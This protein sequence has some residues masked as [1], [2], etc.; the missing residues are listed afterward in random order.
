M[1]T[2][3]SRRKRRLQL[4]AVALGDPRKWPKD[5]GECLVEAFAPDGERA[6]RA[7]LTFENSVRQTTDHVSLTARYASMFVGPFRPQVP[8]YAS[9]WLEEDG[10]P[11]GAVSGRALNSYREAGLSFEKRSEPPDHLIAEL[12]FLFFLTV[13]EQSSGDTRWRDWQ[14]DFFAHC[15]QPWI[16]AFCRALFDAN[17]DQPAYQALSALCSTLHRDF[18]R[19]RGDASEAC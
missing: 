9:A 16:Q 2:D 14:Y 3:I 11:M 15:V 1:S 7:A 18:D 13:Q 4:L 5:L 6:Y 19:Y 17:G 8:P 10:M 12:E